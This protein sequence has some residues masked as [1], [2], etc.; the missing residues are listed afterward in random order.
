MNESEHDLNRLL[1]SAAKAPKE[2][3]DGPSPALEQ[4]ILA[5]WRSG[6]EAVE[7]WFTHLPLYRR[8]LVVACGLT[9]V[10]LIVYFPDI[11][12]DS[13]D[14]VDLVTTPLDMTSLP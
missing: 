8:A 2:T 6:A 7:E 5:Q 12:G 11:T 1:R 3:P 14:E 13:A 9:L 4:R 10:A